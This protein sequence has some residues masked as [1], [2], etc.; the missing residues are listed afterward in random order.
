M[1]LPDLPGGRSQQGRHISLQHLQ[2]LNPELP[3]NKTF[4]SRTKPRGQALLSLWSINTTHY[5]TDGLDPNLEI[6][7]PLSVSLFT[8]PCPQK[9]WNI[10]QNRGPWQAGGSQEKKALLD[11]AKRVT[12]SGNY[13]RCKCHPTELKSLYNQTRSYRPSLKEI[14]CLLGKKK[15]KEIPSPFLNSLSS[16]QLQ[17][18]LTWRQAQHS[19]GHSVMPRTVQAAGSHQLWPPVDK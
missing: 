18:L 13:H 16:C 15:R 7:P 4:L 3:T 12:N 2:M 11:Y 14:P 1:Q 8:T 9:A 10:S 19:V 17:D 6:T 5:L